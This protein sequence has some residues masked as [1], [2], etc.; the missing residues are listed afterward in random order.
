VVHRVKKSLSLH[1][2][3]DCI[4][5]MVVVLFCLNFIYVKAPADDKINTGKYVYNESLRMGFAIIR[6]KLMKNAIYYCGY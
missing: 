3:N 2:M 6:V 5:S 1:H 4:S